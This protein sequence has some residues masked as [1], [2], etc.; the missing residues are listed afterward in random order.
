M[1]A[2]AMS[3][4]SKPGD[5]PTNPVLLI[6]LQHGING[7]AVDL[8]AV[9]AHTSNLAI[10]KGLAVELWDSHINE[11]R[12]T[13][14]GIE[15][16][17]DR[18]WAELRTKLLSMSADRGRS[19]RVSFVGH[20]MGG[21][22]LR[23]VAT[24]LHEWRLESPARR[25]T[26]LDTYLMVATP[27]LGC[28]TLGQEALGGL[29]VAVR[30]STAIMRAGLRAIGGTTGADLLF[31][32]TALDR[33]SGGVY[34]EALRA[35]ER[36]VTV[37]NLD[38]DWVCPFACASLLDAAEIAYVH[39]HTSQL[40]RTDHANVLWAPE[41][42]GAKQEPAAVADDVPAAGVAASGLAA[43][44]T[45]SMPPLL[46]P[47]TVRLLP[48]ALREGRCVV[49]EPFDDEWDSRETVAVHRTWDDGGKARRAVDILR[50]LRACGPWEV[51]MAKFGRRASFL[52]GVFT[53][54]VDIIAIPLQVKKEHGLE[55]VNHIASLLLRPPT[56]D[57][58]EC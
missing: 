57:G 12:R 53:P 32:S 8:D 46:P 22:I 18:L 40:D 6:V 13:H 35:F 14:H 3:A 34:A 5:V 27:H 51:H 24:R 29:G 39:S 50:S 26:V 44:Q 36:R 43:A 49:A 28:R 15:K 7:H 23:V 41:Q 52:S 48:R 19:V 25:S 2:A 21:L 1:H 16:C 38:G 20:S 54:H 55:V 58:V 37:S 9:R 11:G 45:T 47:R 31:D 17:G 30:S 42:A 56:L 33:I 4:S 10:V